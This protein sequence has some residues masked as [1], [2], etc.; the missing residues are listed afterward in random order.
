MESGWA[1]NQLSNWNTRSCKREESLVYSL[2]CVLPPHLTIKGDYCFLLINYLSLAFGTSKHAVE[3]ATMHREQF[4]KHRCW[5]VPL[6]AVNKN[7]SCPGKIRRV[8]I[9]WKQ[10]NLPYIGKLKKKIRFQ[11]SN[12]PETCLLSLPEKVLRMF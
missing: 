1:C 9:Y 5:H 8:L 12:G 7:A 4:I 10:W 6:K 2:C 3:G 11:K